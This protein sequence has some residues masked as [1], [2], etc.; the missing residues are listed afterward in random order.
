MPQMWI[1]DK[2]SFLYDMPKCI[3]IYSKRLNNTIYIE[4]V[5]RGSNRMVKELSQ[6][7][8]YGKFRGQNF[9]LEGKNCNT[10]TLASLYVRLF[11]WPMSDG[12]ARMSGTICKLEWGVINKPYNGKEKFRKI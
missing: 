6:I 7:P 3:M 4:G 8:K 5:D 12:T 9:L 11:Q 2:V 1:W 10:L